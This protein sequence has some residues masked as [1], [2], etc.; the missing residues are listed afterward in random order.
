LQAVDPVITELI[1]LALHG[2]S[3]MVRLRACIDVLD[4]AGLAPVQQIQVT[5]VDEAAID[6]EIERL[7]VQMA[8][9]DR[10]ERH[11]GDD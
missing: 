8:G 4:R 9:I 1:H 10:Q 2:E 7:L 5:D 6:R 11:R 3:E